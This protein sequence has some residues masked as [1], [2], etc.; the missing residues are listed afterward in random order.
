VGIEGGGNIRVKKGIDSISTKERG[1]G[2]KRTKAGI[3]RSRHPSYRRAETNSKEQ[4]KPAG[5]LKT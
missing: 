3:H 2:E 1:K 4:T 5:S